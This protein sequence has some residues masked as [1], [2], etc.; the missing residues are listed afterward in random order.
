LQSQGLSQREA[1][2]I[3][4][5]RRRSS[6]EKPGIKALEDPPL[7]KRITE[8]A[9]SRPRSGYRRLY[10]AYEREARDGDPYMNYKR[11]WRLYR[12]GNLQIS[13][14]RHRSRAKYVRGVPMRRAD[15]PNEIWTMDFVPVGCCTSGLSC[16]DAAR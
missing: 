7:I 16:V 6:N 10:D 8:L 15:R 4:R 9:Q 3:V 2:K 14:R 5:A 1:C 12:L 13:K 11:F